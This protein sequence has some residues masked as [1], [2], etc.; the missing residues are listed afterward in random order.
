MGQVIGPDR[1][2][3]VQDDTVEGSG[4]GPQNQRDGGGDEAWVSEF[5]DSS[6]RFV[7]DDW[8]AVWQT[9]DH[10]SPLDYVSWTGAEFSNLPAFNPQDQL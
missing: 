6:L 4:A 3:R 10:A 7:R 5:H 2:W 9:D 8:F 1:F